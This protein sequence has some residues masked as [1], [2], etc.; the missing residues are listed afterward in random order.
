MLLKWAGSKKNEREAILPHLRNALSLNRRAVYIEPFIGSGWIAFSLC[1]QRSII[2]DLLPELGVLYRAVQI[3]PDD[4]MDEVCRMVKAGASEEAYLL[5]RR[6]DTSAMTEVQQAAR[7]IYLNRL[8]FNGLWRTN[9]KGE[10]NVPYGKRDDPKL[11]SKLDF[12][13]VHQALKG[14]RVLTGPYLKAI[15]LAQP[16]DVVFMDPPYLGTFEGYSGDKDN[17]VEPA[18][19]RGHIHRLVS[20]GVRVVATLP[21][22]KE[23]ERLA[24]F[25]D[26][27]DISR[28]TPISATDRGQLKQ[29]LWISR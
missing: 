18:D 21:E 9:S 3:R 14:T 28:R 25:M 19:I 13:R 23:Y 15:A 24:G 8:G 27:E 4:V 7:M 26:S 10:N 5:E 12:I 20:S 17:A 1:H 6:R 29:T 22:H 11:P 16:G 2:N